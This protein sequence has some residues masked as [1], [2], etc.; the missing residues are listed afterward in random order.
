[1]YVRNK[2]SDCTQTVIHE[3]GER[4]QPTTRPKMFVE[5]LSKW[6]PDTRDSKTW[7][8][9]VDAR[10]ALLKSAASKTGNAPSPDLTMKFSGLTDPHTTPAR[11]SSSRTDAAVTAHTLTIF[12]CDEPNGTKRFGVLRCLFRSAC[13]THDIQSIA[14]KEECKA[15]VLKRGWR[16][17]SSRWEANIA[18]RKRGPR[19]LL[20]MCL[21]NERNDQSTEIDEPPKMEGSLANVHDMTNTSKP[22][23][24]PYPPNRLFQHNQLKPLEVTLARRSHLRR[25]LTGAWD[26]DG[27]S[28][29]S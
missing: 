21:E 17:P 29:A 2:R 9:P 1:M 26:V 3:H 10:A 4:Q 7:H 25:C 24:L 8:L 22:Q 5:Y 27:S 15:V 18:H 28:S 23:C 20:Y 16:Q 19:V 13:F 14:N 12:C 11:C 6:T